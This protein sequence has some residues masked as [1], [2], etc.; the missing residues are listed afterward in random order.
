MFL[1]YGEVKEDFLLPESWHLVPHT[2]GCIRYD[3][4]NFCLNTLKQYASLR[5]DRSEVL[6]MGLIGH[7]AKFAE[8]FCPG[9]RDV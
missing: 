4:L 7:L 1:E 8:V 9:I 6:F 5:R 2:L 3:G